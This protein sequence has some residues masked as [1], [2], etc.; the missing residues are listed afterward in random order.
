MVW[1]GIIFNAYTDLHI[2]DGGKINYLR[3]RDEVLRPLVSF[4]RSK[5]GAT[6]KF[7]PPRKIEINKQLINI[8]EINV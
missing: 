8:Y 6:R 2:F 1:A 4:F 3:Q 7:K 5:K